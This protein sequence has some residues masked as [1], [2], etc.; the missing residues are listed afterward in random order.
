MNAL[1]GIL[2]ETDKLNILVPFPFIR[3]LHANHRTIFHFFF[4]HKISLHAP[5]PSNYSQSGGTPC[6]LVWKIDFYGLSCASSDTTTPR[7][8]RIKWRIM[9]RT[10]S[11]RL[12]WHCGHHLRTRNARR[13]GQGQIPRAF[14]FV[15]HSRHLKDICLSFYAVFGTVF[16]S[17]TFLLANNERG[18]G[19]R[20]IDWNDSV[21]SLALATHCQYICSRCSGKRRVPNKKA[22]NFSND[23]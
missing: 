10:A 9:A 23:Q 2:L 14:P 18:G 4:T 1:R 8:R 20:G 19:W 17:K 21:I 3:N 16:Y 11:G 7:R 5:M 22:N 6:Q 15:S 12:R 13:E